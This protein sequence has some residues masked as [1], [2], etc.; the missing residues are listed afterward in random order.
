MLSYPVTLV[1]DDND[2]YLVDFAD[3]PEAHSVGDTEADALREAVDGLI[4]T[5][6]IYMDD[7]RVVPLPSAP[8]PEQPTVTLPAL[9][10]AKLLLWN[11]MLK[12][13]MRK[14]DLA[15]LLNVHQPQIDRLFDL[16]HSSKLDF[17]EQ[18]ADAL[19][20]RLSIRLV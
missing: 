14:A 11:E 12:K 16:R 1:P 13:R 10:T 3:F 15:R 9:E 7:R 20:R 4:T 6:G 19:G 18:A 2:T 5:V 17:V 8:G